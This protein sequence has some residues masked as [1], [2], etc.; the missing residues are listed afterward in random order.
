MDVTEEVAGSARRRHGLC[1]TAIIK[2]DLFAWPDRAAKLPAAGMLTHGFRT[3]FWK[4]R[5]SWIIAVV[6]DVD[7]GRAFDRFVAPRRKASRE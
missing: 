2:L 7:A 3:V 4:L 6:S 1:V 5:R